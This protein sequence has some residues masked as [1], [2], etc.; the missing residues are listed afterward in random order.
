MYQSAELNFKTLLL[1]V[2][3]FDGLIRRKVLPPTLSKLKQAVTESCNQIKREKTMETYCA[4][5]GKQLTQDG[6]LLNMFHFFELF[7]FR[8]EEIKMEFCSI[9]CR[10]DF[11]MHKYSAHRLHQERKK[12]I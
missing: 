3:I 4:K 9:K 6:K 1:A 10:K 7:S 12:R 11:S 2:S 8:M 5:C